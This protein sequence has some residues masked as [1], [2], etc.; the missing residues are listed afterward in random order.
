MRAD[1]EEDEE[2]DMGV[3]IVSMSQYVGVKTRKGRVLVWSCGLLW[4]IL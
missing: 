2:E 4:V 1:N 3:E